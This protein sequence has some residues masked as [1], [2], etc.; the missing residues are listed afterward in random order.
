MW[1]RF[2]I[3]VLTC[4]V[5]GLALGALLVWTVQVEVRAQLRSEDAD[6]APSVAWYSPSTP[7]LASD[8]GVVLN[9]VR[10][11]RATDF[12]ALVAQLKEAPAFAHWH[13]A[14]STEHSPDGSIVY[15]LT[16]DTQRPGESRDLLLALSRAFPT[17]GV[18]LYARFMHACTSKQKVVSLTPAIVQ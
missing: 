13:V 9:F 18:A 3:T 14:R 7:V 5:G 4:F 12:E 2:L 17:D 6:A 16:A 8:E 1:R 15:L 10:P 11:D